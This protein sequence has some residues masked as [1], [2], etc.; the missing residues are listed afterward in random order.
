[1]LVTRDR[2][3]GSG[4]GG[5]GE[6]IEKYTMLIWMIYPIEMMSCGSFVSYFLMTSY[7]SFVRHGKLTHG[8]CLAL[9]K[10]LVTIIVKASNT[11]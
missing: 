9:T 3:V 10:P 6:K 1:M 4:R 5:G 2:E 8:T 11:I 7:I